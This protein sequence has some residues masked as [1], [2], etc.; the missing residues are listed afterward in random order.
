[1]Y[2]CH[3]CSMWVSVPSLG[4]LSV[5][6][7]L[8]RQKGFGYILSL[9]TP[10]PKY[11]ATLSCVELC[12]AS[13]VI[14]LLTEFSDMNHIF[15]KCGSISFRLRGELQRV[16]CEF[17]AALR[18]AVVLPLQPLRRVLP[19]NGNGRCIVCCGCTQS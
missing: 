16:R 13:P 11:T 9:E 1:M 7:L 12:S 3:N 10:L 15:A 19:C 4:A 6:G 14:R 2:G 18:V 17:A 5:D 8:V